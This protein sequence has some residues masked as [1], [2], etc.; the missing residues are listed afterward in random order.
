[1][2]T[3]NNTGK[4]KSLSTKESSHP[5]TETGNATTTATTTVTTTTNTIKSTSSETVEKKKTPSLKIKFTLSTLSRK[6]DKDD[7]LIDDEDE[8]EDEEEE[9]EVEEEEEGE[10]DEEGEAGE[11]T[12]EIQ[13]DVKVANATTSANAN[14]DASSE[15]ASSTT[16]LNQVSKKNN[17]ATVDGADAIDQESE[18][19]EELK[20][21]DVVM[22]EIQDNDEESMESSSIV[23]NGSGERANGTNDIKEGTDE[24]E[25]DADISLAE[26]DKSQSE[27]L[28]TT[29][30]QDKE[31]Q[32][33]EEEKHRNAA[34]TTETNNRPT[35]TRSSYDNK[36]SNNET[37]REK[38]NNDEK[39]GKDDVSL[40]TNNGN[41]T[42][43]NNA[44]SATN[45]RIALATGRD[46]LG[47]REPSSSTTNLTSSFLDSLSEEQR[48]VRTRHL[49]NV[50][51]F[52][53]LHKS[54][55]KRDLSVIKKMLKCAT[56]K[57]GRNTPADEGLN[58]DTENM[59]VSNN[60]GQVSGE[61]SPSDEEMTSTT[62]KPSNKS[63]S[64][65]KNQNEVNADLYKIFSLPYI[66]SP[67]I[68]TD[69]NAKTT[70]KNSK[71]EPALFSSPQV[72]ESITAF[73]PPRPPESVGPK[74]MHRLHRWE[75]NPHDVEVD[76]SNYRKTVNRTRQELHKAEM[77]RERIEVVGAHLR[78]H[79]L[80]QLKCMR[81]EMSLL[82]QQYD[83]TQIKCVKAA[84][85]LT[86]K[87]RSR[88]AS[89]GS[90]V[91]KDVISVLKT[92]G[93]KLDLNTTEGAGKNG[94]SWCV[95]GVGG[96]CA[97][98]TNAKLGCGWLLPGDK[99]SSPY[100]VGVVEK[101]YGPS[102]LDIKTNTSDASN[103]KP[104]QSQ[105]SQ[106][107]E[108]I[109]DDNETTILS[110]RLRVRLPFGVAFFDPSALTLI[111]SS[112]SFSDNKLGDR[113]LAMMESAK[114]MGNVTDSKSFDNYLAI[115][116]AAALSNDEKKDEIE[117]D[118]LTESSM[119]P[120]AA[121]T[122]M[123]I[124]DPSTA[125][126]PNT[127]AKNNKMVS[128]G[129]GILP[130]IENTASDVNLTQLEKNVG[131]LL[132]GSGGVVGV[133]SL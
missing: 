63:G 24:K 5:E 19:V 47:F 114:S 32:L 3:N 26:D 16:S 30:Q 133:V 44:F 46:I 108:Q 56:S 91:M 78:N 28:D 48:R 88:G 121:N 124:D 72:V 49:P 102:K 4:V 68:C 120:D 85:L 119:V 36:D 22:E 7:A 101:V 25:A 74:K 83:A 84:E 37:D 87:T 129:A 62:S 21:E 13:S 71:E 111:G 77:E 95:P 123:D 9:G 61:D 100:G 126:S 132:S 81:Q 125:P 20:E 76:L 117:D 115:Q 27:D 57:G 128:F 60:G 131:S 67:Y 41:S 11:I 94:E 10:I 51:G 66:Q 106:T 45:S 31:S 1:M 6:V 130:I 64:N 14:T 52:R 82:N 105:M 122:D 103:D 93:E 116:R 65:G 73:N 40:D 2:S 15:A 127:A 92:R 118:D 12:S 8:E 59:D 113:W 33:D 55:I 112:S 107:Q 50:S 86:S 79:F 104:P 18:V 96:V 35:R 75:R 54:E 70:N 53:R 23:V 43:N 17:K 98:K 89:R 99:V 110:T 39:G 42:S 69:A 34:S 38:A 90:Y 80:T 29:P 97:H 109:V 58:N